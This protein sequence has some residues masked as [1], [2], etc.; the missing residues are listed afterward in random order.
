MNWPNFWP[1]WVS[2]SSPTAHSTPISKKD[3]RDTLLIARVHL[4]IFVMRKK[5][6]DNIRNTLLTISV[7][8]EMNDEEEVEAEITR[9][10]VDQPRVSSPEKA[11]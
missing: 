4:R 8:E 2:M 3:R 10:I 11:N 1:I 7:S 5:T 9:E 6:K